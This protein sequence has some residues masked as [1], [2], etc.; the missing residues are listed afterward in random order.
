[1]KRPPG[2]DV[3][4]L[5]AGAGLPDPGGAGGAEGGATTGNS[6]ATGAASAVAAPAGRSRDWPKA[7][8]SGLARPLRETTVLTQ[9]G[10]SPGATPTFPAMV[11]RVSPSFTT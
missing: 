6:G 7:R 2:A 8:S 4:T 10:W 11:R 9:P 1:M 5:G 3:A